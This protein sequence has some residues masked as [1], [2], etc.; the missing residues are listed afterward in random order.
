MDLLLMEI[1]S[2]IY[3]L[4]D[5]NI[6]YTLTRKHKKLLPRSKKRFLNAIERE[7]TLTCEITFLTS[8][9]RHNKLL[10]RTLLLGKMRINGRTPMPLLGKVPLYSRMILPSRTSLG[11]T[12][13]SHCKIPPFTSLLSKK[14]IIFLI[15]LSR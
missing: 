15:S 13:G 9:L 1:P 7:G 14:I 5:Y 6:P 10:G 12:T 8:M 4:I 3:W 2:I 11:F